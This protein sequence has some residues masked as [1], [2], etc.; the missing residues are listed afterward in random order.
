MQENVFQLQ[1]ENWESAVHFANACCTVGN[2]I[3]AA[4]DCGLVASVEQ[5]RTEQKLLCY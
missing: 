1:E 2:F 4:L 5:I 3:P